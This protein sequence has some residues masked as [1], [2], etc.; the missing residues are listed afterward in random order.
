MNSQTG[1]EFLQNPDGQFIPAEIGK[2]ESFALGAFTGAATLGLQVA[3]GVTSGLEAVINL[4]PNVE[5]DFKTSEQAAT[6][7]RIRNLDP[8][9]AAREA[10]PVSNLLGEVAG[11]L[12]IPGGPLASTIISGAASAGIGETGRE[13]IMN[14]GIGMVAGPAAARGGRA[15]QQAGSRLLQGSSLM[16]K[17]NQLRSR[18]AA[19]LE[20]MGFPLSEGDKAPLGRLGQPARERDLITTTITGD[21]V[22]NAEGK[23][24]A[25]N[26]A[27]TKPFG[28]QVDSVSDDFLAT[29]DDEIDTI[30]GRMRDAVPDGIPTEHFDTVYDDMAEIVATG[31]PEPRLVSSADELDSLLKSGDFDGEQYSRWRTRLGEEAR[32]TDDFVSKRKYYEI[33]ES[34]DSSMEKFPGVGPSLRLAN[35]KWRYREVWDKANSLSPQGNVNLASARRNMEAMY[36]KRALRRGE[37]DPDAVAVWQVIRDAQQFPGFQDSGTARRTANILTRT[38][39]RAEREIG[40]AGERLGAATGREFVDT[41][42]E[43]VRDALEGLGIISV[44]DEDQPTNQ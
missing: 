5:L 36:G 25:M 29:V 4:M 26:R 14:F 9:L 17:A 15:V 35:R 1:Q 19:R 31:T 11:Q 21:R 22:V 24:I 30:Y 23:N 37:A 33:I 7:E 3:R 2:G 8:L 43:S 18:A 40:S 10:N 20:R 27:V 13:Q 39:K 44:E 28:R 42:G 6:I 34:L 16:S 32:S 41:T 12:P 38:V